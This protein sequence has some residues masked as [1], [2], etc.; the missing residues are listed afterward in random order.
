MLYL[1]DGYNV[2]RSDPA[3]RGLSLEEQ[4]RALLHRLR[5]SGREILG[6]GSIVVVFDAASGGGAGTLEPSGAVRVVFARSGSADDALVRIVQG[7]R[8]RVVVVSDDRELLGR[9]EVHASGGAES[10]PAS[11][12]FD[13]VRPRSRSRT[14]PGVARDSGLPPGAN[15][16]TEELKD[17]W[18]KEDDG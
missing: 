14:R 16:I 17:L 18:L 12:L 10:R 9:I 8:E 11:S 7:S 5:V 13:G 4:R 15:R 2:T 6:S 3:T 1:V